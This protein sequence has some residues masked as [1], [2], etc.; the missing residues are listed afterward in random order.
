[1]IRLEK[2]ENPETLGYFY[3]PED[4]DD[5]GLIEIKGDEVVI[6]IQANR[7]KSLGV[8]Y[9]GN[10]ARAEVLRLLEARTLVNS[11]ILVWY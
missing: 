5:V 1:M 7:D 3:Y 9:Y 10:K 11:K 8:P 6:T 2:T 4:T